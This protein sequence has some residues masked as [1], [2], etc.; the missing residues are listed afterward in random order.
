MFSQKLCTKPVR[1]CLDF[2]LQKRQIAVLA[3]FRE[4]RTMHTLHLTL[5]GNFVVDFLFDLVIGLTGLFR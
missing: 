5:V 4:L 3:I 1:L 2:Y